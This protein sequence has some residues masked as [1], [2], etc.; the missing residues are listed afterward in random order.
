MGRHRIHPVDGTTAR[1]FG[2]LHDWPADALDWLHA[3]FARKREG[4]GLTYEALLQELGTRWG[5]TWNDSSLSR[6]YGYWSSTLRIEDQA[7]DEAA[8]IVERLVSSPSP[9]LLAAAKQLLQQQR[10]LALTRLEAADPAEVVRLGLAHDRNEIRQAMIALDA[11]RVTLLE[12]KLAVLTAKAGEA[13]KAL[14]AASKKKSLDPEDLR[15]IREQLYGIAGQ[16]EN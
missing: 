6:Y 9:D 3:E 12:K 14:D 13:A 8:A 1:S 4:A 7:R 2:E 11:K 15:T 16:P 5:L 10:L